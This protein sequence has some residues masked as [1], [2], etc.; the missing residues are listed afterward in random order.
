MFQAYYQAQMIKSI[1]LEPALSYIPSPAA[2]PHLNAAW[3]GTLRM[4]I[5][6]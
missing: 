5:L 3:A 6:F 2:S 1:Y 4:I